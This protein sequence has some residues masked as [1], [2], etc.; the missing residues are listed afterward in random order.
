MS[1]YGL[2]KATSKAQRVDTIEDLHRVN[3]WRST[4]G[5]PLISPKGPSIRRLENAVALMLDGVDL[6]DLPKLVRNKSFYISILP[7][8][9]SEK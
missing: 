2:I 9:K 1:Y 7:E 3:K 8:I 5:L 4:K 6:S